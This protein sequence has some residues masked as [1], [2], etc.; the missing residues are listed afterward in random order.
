[1]AVFETKQKP[2]TWQL[3]VHLNE[4]EHEMIVKR[5]TE[6]GLSVTDYARH[7]LAFEMGLVD[8]R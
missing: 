2:R 5:A 7:A 8:A 1:M 6:V 4:D 3:S